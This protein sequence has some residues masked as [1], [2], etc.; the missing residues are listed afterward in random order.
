MYFTFMRSQK[1]SIEDK[2]Y[3]YNRI[4]TPDL[5]DGSFTKHYLLKNV[6]SDCWVF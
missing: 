1:S 2:E 3:L 4:V 5:T 6:L